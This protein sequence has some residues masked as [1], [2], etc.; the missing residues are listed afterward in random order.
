MEKLIAALLSLMISTLTIPDQYKPDLVMDGHPLRL[1]FEDE[2]NG[3]ELDS[4]KWVRADEMKR[5]D[6][7]NYWSDSMTRLNGK[8]QLVSAPVPTEIPAIYLP[9]Q[10]GRKVCSSRATAILRYAPH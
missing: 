10:Y 6:K 7:E 5:Q 4:T 8:G 9:G 3:Q 1:T 2:F